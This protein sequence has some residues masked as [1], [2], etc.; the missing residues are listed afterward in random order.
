M[1]GLLVPAIF[2]ALLYLVIVWRTS[3]TPSGTRSIVGVTFA[4]LAF[5]L[6]S[7]V[8]LLAWQAGLTILF[9]ACFAIAD[10][11][12]SG[13]RLGATLALAIAVVIV[14]GVGYAEVRA[15]AERRDALQVRY[16]LYSVSDRLAYET[17]SKHRAAEKAAPRSLA[18]LVEVELAAAEARSRFA[19]RNRVLGEVHGNDGIGVATDAY[20]L[21]RLENDLATLDGRSME[22]SSAPRRS[23]G[24]GSHEAPR[25][26]EPEPQYVPQPA[27]EQ[28]PLPEYASTDAPVAA[29]PRELLTELHKGAGN[30]FLNPER[31]GYV[32]SRD[33][34]A[35]FEP[36]RFTAMPSLGKSY[37]ANTDGTTHNAV[38]FGSAGETVRHDDQWTLE[39]VDLVSLHKPAGPAVYLSENLPKVDDLKTADTRLLDDFET[40]A[41]AKLRT[42]D[43]VV[44]E[45]AD[46]RIRMVGALR[47]G[48]HCLRCHAGA[49]GE[50]LGA[51]SYEFHHK[52]FV[53]QP[54]EQE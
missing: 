15:V 29:P 44:I 43:D 6:L 36:H 10:W 4:L 13:R 22:L 39:R 51:L 53:P 30:D 18:P 47:A 48:N 9:V 5:S 32:R 54:A 49:R 28:G 17:G 21:A 19:I 50:L 33:Q 16:P 12:L 14:A 24:C 8:L 23:G 52:N 1:F 27:P 25:A 40:R 42:D 34:V 20:L 7:G 11:G 26:P 2:F 37:D 41:L 46:G 3:D 45:Q 31:F 38:M 35:G